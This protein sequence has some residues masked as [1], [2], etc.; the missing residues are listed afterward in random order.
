MYKTVQQEP[1]IMKNLE[2]D[3]QLV[4]KRYHELSSPQQSEYHNIKSKWKLNH[5]HFRILVI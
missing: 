5:T 4:N 3:D 1:V 2:G